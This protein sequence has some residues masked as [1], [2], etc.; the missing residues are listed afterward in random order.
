MPMEAFLLLAK[1]A[2]KPM[3]TAYEHNIPIIDVRNIGRRPVLSQYT[4]AVLAKIKF[5]RAVVKDS[6]LCELQI[7]LILTNLGIRW[8]SGKGRR[9]KT[10]IDESDLN[11]RIYP[12]QPK[13]WCQEAKFPP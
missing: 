10:T 9:T 4:A 7:S 6:Q 5:Q 11:W 8:S 3:T 13:N 2:D 12:N 1:P